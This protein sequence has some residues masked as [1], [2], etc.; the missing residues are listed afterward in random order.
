MSEELKVQRKEALAGE[1]DSLVILLHGYGANGA[2]LLGLAE[3][4]APSLPNTAFISPD[5]PQQCDQHAA[6]RQWFPLEAAGPVSG[7]HHVHQLVK[8]FNI[9]DQFLDKEIAD[10]GIPDDRA[11]LVGFSQGTMMSL[12]V[13]VRR[14]RRLAGIVGFSGLLLRPTLLESEKKSSPPVL[15]VH[16]EEDELISSNSSTD[17]AAALNACGIKTHCYTA[18]GLGHS[19]DMFGIGLALHFMKTSLEG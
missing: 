12:Q 18:P 16:G 9:L 8:S 10:A 19:I 15:L 4:W 6:G 7:M 3:Y 5:A 2:D 13:G 17:A 1:A 14:Q 11:I